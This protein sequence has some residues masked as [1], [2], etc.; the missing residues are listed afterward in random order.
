M[1]SEKVVLYRK[2]P[3]YC[4]Y[5]NSTYNGCLN[6]L[7][8]LNVLEEKDKLDK[9]RRFLKLLLYIKYS[10]FIWSFVFFTIIMVMNCSFTF[11]K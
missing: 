8:N 3:F 6:S 4:T 5:V 9:L 2:F 11:S 1:E 10:K 7:S